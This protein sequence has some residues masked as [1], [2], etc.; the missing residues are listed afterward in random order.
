MAKARYLPREVKV[1]GY[2]PGTYTLDLDEKEAE[3]IRLL[4]GRV[5]GTG[6]WRKVS[7]S[8]F[9]ELSNLG[10]SNY[11]SPARFDSIFKK[12]FSIGVRDE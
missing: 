12:L 5:A 6:P 7:G 9:E 1:S 4:V 10:P 11:D 8:I 2:S 3:L